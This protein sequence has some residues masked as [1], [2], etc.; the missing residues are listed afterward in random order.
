MQE[1]GNGNLA[2]WL[3]L[4]FLNVFLTAAAVGHETW[5]FKANAIAWI[6]YATSRQDWWYWLTELGSGEHRHQ[7]FPG[8]TSGIA[9]HD[10]H[11]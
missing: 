10:H 5:L 11:T 1:E 2:T 4:F 9:K 3:L 7:T 8:K 6:V